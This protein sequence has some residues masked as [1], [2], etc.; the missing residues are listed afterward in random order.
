MTCARPVS[1]LPSGWPYSTSFF[2]A[3]I[4]ERPE[5]ERIIPRWYT[6]PCRIRNR[7]AL[8]P[9]SPGGK[10]DNAP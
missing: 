8:S 1:I 3:A 10:L 9:F 6:G 4:V 2:R 5:R 7:P